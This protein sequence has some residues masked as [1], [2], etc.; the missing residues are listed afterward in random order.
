M[1]SQNGRSGPNVV[2]SVVLSQCDYALAWKRKPLWLNFLLVGVEGRARRMVFTAY[3]ICIAGL[4]GSLGHFDNGCIC[5]AQARQREAPQAHVWKGRGG[6]F[7]PFTFC[8]SVDSSCF[9]D[10]CSSVKTLLMVGTTQC[11]IKGGTAS[12]ARS[13][14]VGWSPAVFSV[15]LAPALVAAVDLRPCSLV[16]AL[17]TDPVCCCWLPTGSKCL[18]KASSAS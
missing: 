16:W 13:S 12:L 7:R 11:T 3:L 6:R 5:K 4:L 18:K 14:G 9:A 10:S 2:M 1:P 8:K 15:A 17:R